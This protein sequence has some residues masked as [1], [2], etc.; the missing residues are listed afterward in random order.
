MGGLG[1]GVR[2]L[3]DPAVVRARLEALSNVGTNNVSVTGDADVSQIGSNWTGQSQ[4]T[5]ATT[6]DAVAGSQVTGVVV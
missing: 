1:A 3:V 6:G 4:D 5:S 2:Y